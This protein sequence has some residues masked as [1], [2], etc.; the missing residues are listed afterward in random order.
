MDSSILTKLFNAFGNSALINMEFVADRNPKVHSSF[1][2]A[3]CETEEDVAAKI[4]EWL[5]RDAYKSEH[6]VS[7]KKN[8]QV[9]EY[10]LN[11]IN[12][13]LGTKFTPKDVEV[14]YT[15]LGN[16]VNDAKTREFIRS[17]YNMEV[18]KDD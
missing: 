17:G 18:L 4:L 2:F 15:K 10:H 11:G 16:A 7:Q 12:S 8:N 14:V 3:D 6:Y 9:H 13:F 1:V 5:S